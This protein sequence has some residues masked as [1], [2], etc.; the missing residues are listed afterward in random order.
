MKRYKVKRYV[1]LCVCVSGFLTAVC[2]PLP[3]CFWSIGWSIRPC[4][5]HPAERVSFHTLP[6]SFSPPATPSPSLLL[7]L[8]RHLRTSPTTYI[9]SP[10]VIDGGY[11]LPPTDPCAVPRTHNTFGDRSF[12]VAG[13]R[14]W[15]SLPAHFRDEDISYNSFRRE[16]KTFLF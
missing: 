14:V 3:S 15:N 11:A 8:A 13:P 7:C 10:K 9:W 12:A 4:L 16:L 6:S 2:R 5:D 1:G